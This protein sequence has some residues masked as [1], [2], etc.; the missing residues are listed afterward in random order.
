MTNNEIREHLDNL[1]GAITFEYNGYSCGIDPISTDEFDM[2]Y[3][4]ETITVI[5]VDEVME[6]DFFDGKPLESILDD[7]TD[8]D[9]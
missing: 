3:G 5:S 7:T 2:W 6:T 9:Y 8:F 1:I 4:D